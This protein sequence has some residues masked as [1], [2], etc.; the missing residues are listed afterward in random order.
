MLGRDLE[1]SR[2]FCSVFCLFRLLQKC[3]GELQALA[4]PIC[5]AGPKVGG[6]SGPKSGTCFLPHKE[7]GFVGLIFH[8]SFATR[9]CLCYSDSILCYSC[10]SEVPGVTVCLVFSCALILEKCEALLVLY[11]SMALLALRFQLPIQLF[12]HGL[13][14]F[15]PWTN[16]FE[17]NQIPKRIV[18]NHGRT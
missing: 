12:R 16:Q 9:L 13:G 3:G 2:R 1:R 11:E 4:M 8:S 10:Y 15:L 14:S 5:I 7:E 6:V 17:A 18:K